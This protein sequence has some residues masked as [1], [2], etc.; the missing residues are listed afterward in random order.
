MEHVVKHRVRPLVF[1]VVAIAAVAGRASA[2]GRPVQEAK[3]AGT[4][5]VVR[6]FRTEHGP[7]ID[8]V[9]RTVQV[10]KELIDGR[11]KTTLSDGRES[12]VIE[13]GPGALSVVSAAGRVKAA[14][15]DVAA[16]DRA[17][18][19]VAR[20]PLTRKATTLIGQLTFGDTSPIQP[21]LLSTRAFL[22]SASGD[23]SGTDDLVSWTR[24]VRATQRVSKVSLAQRTPTQCWEAYG[25]EIVDAYTEYAY[26][27]THLKWYDIFGEKG[28]AV[29][30]EARIIGAFAWY[31]N[32]VAIRPGPGL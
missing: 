7:R 21:L 13:A 10:R 20:S 2:Q 6:I 4:G 29:V 31:F 27:A 8:L 22:L 17:Q 25:N 1:A 28:C 11:V 12:L 3:D 23:R 19:L 32:C 18:Q 9:G 15:K 5:A 16:Y 26:C 30:Y 14:G 24:R